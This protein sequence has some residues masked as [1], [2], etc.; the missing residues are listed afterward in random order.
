MGTAN[1]SDEQAAS[2][3]ATL[4]YGYQSFGMTYCSYFQNY[5]VLPFQGHREDC[6]HIP[7][8]IAH[9][10]EYLSYKQQRLYFIR[11]ISGK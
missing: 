3:R 6:T 1:I 2:F 10:P 11:V 4:G 8:S 5:H 9:N 7:V